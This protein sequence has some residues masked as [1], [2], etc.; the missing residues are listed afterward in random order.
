M[1]RINDFKVMLCTEGK[2]LQVEAM[3]VCFVR[4]Y[5]SLMSDVTKPPEDLPQLVVLMSEQ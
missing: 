3:L 2:S 4:I 1:P 5:C